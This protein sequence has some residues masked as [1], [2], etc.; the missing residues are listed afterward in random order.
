M[1][2]QK[3]KYV[4]AAKAEG[5]VLCPPMITE[6]SIIRDY[7]ISLLSFIGGHNT[8]LEHHLLG[9][10]KAVPQ[11]SRQKTIRKIA[12][13]KEYYTGQSDCRLQNIMPIIGIS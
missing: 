9:H 2:K 11:Q 1:K 10:P 6:K 8:A 4:E 3:N 5:Q 12:F 13:S 7:K